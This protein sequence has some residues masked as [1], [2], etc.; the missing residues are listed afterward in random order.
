MLNKKVLKLIVIAPLLLVLV[1][2]MIFLPLA[3]KFWHD[4]RSSHN[5]EQQS[6]II[7]KLN[8]ELKEIIDN[9]LEQNLAENKG[10]AIINSLEGIAGSNELK[11]NIADCEDKKGLCF[12]LTTKGTFSEILSIIKGLEEMPFVNAIEKTIIRWQDEDES[13]LTKIKVRVY[14]LDDLPL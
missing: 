3:N 11:I 9:P 12:D 4:Y 14:T 13:Y 8:Q 10:L 5:Q 2:L 7:K 1:F 6:V